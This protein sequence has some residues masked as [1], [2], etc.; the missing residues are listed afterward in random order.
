MVYELAPWR[1]LR[2]L[3]A[4]WTLLF[5]AILTQINTFYLTFLKRWLSCPLCQ[6]T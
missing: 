1:P 4:T 5:E 6:P 2:T 3:R